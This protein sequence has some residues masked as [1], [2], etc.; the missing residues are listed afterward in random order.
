MP[1]QLKISQFTGI[2]EHCLEEV[3]EGRSRLSKSG[4]RLIMD[5]IWF[6]MKK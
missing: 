5:L 1:K 4:D 6:K 2:E 3:Y